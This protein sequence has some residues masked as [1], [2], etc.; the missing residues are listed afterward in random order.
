[1]DKEGASYQMHRVRVTGLKPKTTYFFVVDSAH[2]E[3]TG[4]EAKS[5][6]AQFQTK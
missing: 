1:V 6:V 2:G 5:Q 3:D 4:T